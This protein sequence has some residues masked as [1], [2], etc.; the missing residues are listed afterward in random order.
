MTSNRP[1][2]FFAGDH[3]ALDFLNTIATPRDV[4]FEWLA[5]GKDLIDWL[6]QAG[7]I[8]AEE[9]ARFR[10]SKRA[11]SLDEVARRAREFRDWLRGFVTRHLGKPLP[12]RRNRT[13]Q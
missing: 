5:D 13:T 2:A 3:L 6:Q 8:G 1:P 9:A 11:G 10:E 7:M 4:P 12:A